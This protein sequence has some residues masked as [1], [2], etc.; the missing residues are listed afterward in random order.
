MGK[1]P[2]G[3]K[4]SKRCQG[5]KKRLPP[6]SFRYVGASRDGL[7]RWCKT[8]SGT[9][10]HQ[11]LRMR[12]NWLLLKYG[13]TLMEYE[14]LLVAQGRRCAICRRLNREAGE[15]ELAVDHCHKTGRIRGLLCTPCNRILGAMGDDVDGAMRFVNYLRGAPAWAGSEGRQ[16][17]RKVITRFVNAEG[18]RVSSATPGAI[19]VRELSKMFYVRLNN[20]YVS[21]G[22][23]D[24]AVAKQRAM[25]NY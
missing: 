13:I 12:E 21:L 8:C 5:C 9:P 18:Q 15:R 19:R 11:R 23:T 2:T 6:Q 20:R 3:E 10:E 17:V 16:P 7:A 4:W 22:T 25:G 1:K 14:R 24:E